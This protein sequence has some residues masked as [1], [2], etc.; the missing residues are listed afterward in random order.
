MKLT[1]EEKAFVDKISAISGHDPKSVKEIFSALMVASTLEIYSRSNT[2]YIP[3]LF[4]VNITYDKEH[5]SKGFELKEKYDVETSR[6]LH[7][8]ILKINSGDK[9]QSDAYLKKEIVK[10]ISSVLEL[11]DEDT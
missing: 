5:T 11:E 9:T 4:K 2:V 6:T 1:P 10:H 3:Y 7:D 8:S